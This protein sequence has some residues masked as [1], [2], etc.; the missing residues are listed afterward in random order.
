MKDRTSELIERL[1]DLESRD[2]IDQQIEDLFED[3]KESLIQR[4]YDL[5]SSTNHL[6][7]G[8]RILSRD[9]PDYEFYNELNFIKT[10]LEGNWVAIMDDYE[11]YMEIQN[12]INDIT[13]K[14]F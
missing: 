3:L 1:S 8:Q 4:G 5:E 13:S 14:F 6:K 9:Y 7:G 12:A 10:G 11:N 2:E